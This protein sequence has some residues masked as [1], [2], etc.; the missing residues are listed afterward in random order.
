MNAQAR[1]DD[2]HGIAAHFARAR[3]M[4]NRRAVFAAEG[5]KLVVGTG[6]R[7][8]AVF[9][10]HVRAQGVGAGQADNAGAKVNA[11]RSRLLIALSLSP[12]CECGGNRRYLALKSSSVLAVINYKY[13]W[14][15][16]TM[17]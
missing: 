14:Q 9:L 7:A 5:Q 6:G 17:N 8:G 10:P 4:E 1:I 3:W 13:G 15:I 12:I 2:G 16:P 11:K